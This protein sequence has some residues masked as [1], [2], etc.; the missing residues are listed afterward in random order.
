VFFILGI[1]FFVLGGKTII[2]AQNNFVK[3]IYPFLFCFYFGSAQVVLV[4]GTVTESDGL[5]P[6]VGVN[7]L[8][9]D[10][11]EGTTTDHEGAFH[12]NLTP[13]V[14]KIKVSYLGYRSNI[15]TV[16]IPNTKVYTLPHIV[17]ET[18]ELDEVVVT[19]SIKKLKRLDSPIPIEVYSPKFFK[20]N[21]SSSVF[22]ALQQVNGIRPQV[23]C[24]V[25]G[26]GDIHINGQEGANTMVLIDGMPMVSGLSTIYGLTGI[27]ISIID[28]VEIIK[29]P[30]STLYGSEAMAGVINLITKD[31]SLNQ[32]PLDLIISRSDWNEFTGDISFNS[33]IGENLKFIT[34][35]NIHSYNETVDRN[36]DGFTDIPLK[37]S[38][39]FFQ[40]INFN[41]WTVGFKGQLEERWGG[42]TDWQK[43]YR[44]TDTKY[45]EWV[46]TQ[47]TNLFGK[48]DLN[49]NDF[50]QF[51]LSNHK[52][53]AYY[54]TTEFQA[55]QKIAFGQWVHQWNSRVFDGFLG[56]SHRATYF[57]DNS[58]IF[59]DNEWTHLSGAFIQTTFP[60]LRNAKILTGIR[61]DIHSNHGLIITPRLNLH[62]NNSNNIDVVRMGVGSGYRVVQVFSEDHAALTGSRRVVF[63]EKLAPEK[64]WNYNLQ[65][66]HMMINSKNSIVKWDVS[67]F[68]TN[69]SNRIL[70]DL[71]K[72]P[73]EIRYRNLDGRAEVKGASLGVLWQDFTDKTAR[74]SGTLLSSKLIEEGVYKTPY[75]SESTSV[76]YS[77]GQSILNNLL[78]LN[79][80][81]QIIG[82]M[83]LPLLGPLDPR[84][85][86][87]PWMHIANIEFQ[88]QFNEFTFSLGV[89]N[90]L[91]SKPLRESIARSFDP[92]DKEV[93]FDKDN[94]PVSTSNN[95][96]ALSFDPSYSYMSQQGIRS[97][98][99]IQWS[100]K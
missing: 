30:A 9:I 12:L 46:D 68:L 33:V 87:S 86:H 23:N 17:L 99:S 100:F 72:H 79:L 35:I 55:L 88:K 53:L 73:E 24:G 15:Q 50:F 65:W 16:H 38:L 84:P 36:S 25:C 7:I 20:A 95:P 92:F 82:P 89:N 59:N 51:S 13:G 49:K 5:T 26:T 77:Y 60:V 94:R 57:K 45:G 6:L 70:P 58:P 34:G 32:T 39:G 42:Q 4:S 67:L 41:K 28:Q 21:P 27:P 69:F 78:K 81:G 76:N 37:K 74:L 85:S 63:E 56:V 97:F 80:N 44:G 31:P 71:E 47:W 48:V 19:S 61:T 96:N 29:G 10:T 40:K 64:S 14:A 3:L 62:W 66:D 90:L 11:N 1:H 98:V 83:R 8:A 54:G 75:F 91:D 2:F 43:I 52:Q 22:Q 18:D 93:T